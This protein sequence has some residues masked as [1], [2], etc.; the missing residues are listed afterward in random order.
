MSKEFD[1]ELRWIK[2][3]EFRSDPEA[4]FKRLKISAE[5]GNI[6]SYSHLGYAYLIV[7]GMATAAL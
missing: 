1:N 6:N 5:E 7:G 3:K 2:L 4:A